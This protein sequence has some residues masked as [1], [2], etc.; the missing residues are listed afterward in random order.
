MQSSKFKVKNIP[1]FP[2][3]RIHF[4]ASYKTS[5]K[6]D[7]LS[8]I[9]TN[10][11]PI[12]F[13]QKFNLIII[14]IIEQHVLP[15]SAVQSRLLQTTQTA[16][17]FHSYISAVNSEMKTAKHLLS[18]KYNKHQ[19]APTNIKTIILAKWER[20]FWKNIY[21]NWSNDLIKIILTFSIQINCNIPFK[22][23][24]FLLY[25]PSQTAQPCMK[26]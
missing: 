7:K 17:N 2:I 21:I 4:Y 20:K 23:N 24:Q 9:K 11:R 1:G 14:I 22:A 13:Q 5:K 18:I 15:L 26:S 12:N 10:R 16:Q 19:K 6:C 25:G 3:F 8:D